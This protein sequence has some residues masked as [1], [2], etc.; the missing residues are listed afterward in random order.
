MKWISY[1]DSPLG[2]LLLAADEEGL[3]GLWMEGQKYYAR[4]LN[5]D[6]KEKKTTAIQE[7]MDW[8]DAYFAGRPLP[9]FPAVHLQGTPFQNHVWQLM[10]E[11][12]YGTTTSY[13]EIAFRMARDL[14]RTSMSAQAV[15][16]AVSKNPILILYPCHR[17]IGANG[18]LTGYAGGLDRKVWLLNHE[19]LD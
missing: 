12:P 2:R 10:R 17:V 18:S 6:A 9:V 5:P 4:G 8:L 19:G 11:I 3:C 16:N 1:Y 15:G 13:K 7:T 14:G